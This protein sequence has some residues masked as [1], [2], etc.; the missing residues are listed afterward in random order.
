[1]AG[2]SFSLEVVLE[3]RRLVERQRMGDLAGAQREYGVLE[4][5]LRRMND[6]VQAAVEDLRRNR[7][8]GV[9]DTA[10]LAAHR[11]FTN[12]A[13][14]RAQEIVQKM[15][16]AQR[17]VLE[18]KGRLAQAAK[19]RKAVEKLRE[20]KQAEWSAEAARREFAEL[21]EVGMQMGYVRSVEAAGGVR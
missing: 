11:R 19:E 18:A 6:A 15:A 14:R 12:A 16:Q 9:L 8:V 10:F 4:E 3:H 5:E 17:R 2:F 7:L 13:G 21:D 1:M 20:R